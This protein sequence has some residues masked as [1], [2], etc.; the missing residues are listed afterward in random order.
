MIKSIFSII[1]LFLAQITIAQIEEL[2]GFELIWKGPVPG[3]EDYTREIFNDVA[4]HFTVRDYYINGFYQMIGTYRSIDPEIEDGDFL[5]FHSNG[6]ISHQGKYEN[7]QLV[8]D[9]LI[10][11][12]S[13]ELIKNI[14]YDF[15]VDTWIGDTTCTAH[16]EAVDLSGKDLSEYIASEMVYP[17]RA[18]KYNI[19]GTVAIQIRINKDGSVSKP[20]VTTTRDKD[21]DKEAL[22]I[23]STIPDWKPFMHEGKPVAAYYS[24]DVMFIIDD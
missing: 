4:G 10:Y 2:E 12:R 7:G 11:D 17:P 19:Q 14:N 24:C 6:Q 16:D 3:G 5:F 21:L 23:I 8:G 13:G 15:K 1:L 20:G 22:R 9:W 18:Y